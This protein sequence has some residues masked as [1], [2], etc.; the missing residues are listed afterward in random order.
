MSWLP[1]WNS[2][3]STAHWHT[4][5]ELGGIALFLIVV[6]FEILAYF[7]GHRRDDLM[8]AASKTQVREREQAEA[9]TRKPHALS[10]RGC[11]TRSTRPTRGA[12]SDPVYPM[13]ANTHS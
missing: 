12:A 6:A 4:F 3:D 9:E 13:P 11:V 7:Y 8:E 5:Y 10:S 1:G 2:V